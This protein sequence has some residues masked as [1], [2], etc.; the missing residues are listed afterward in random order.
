MAIHMDDSLAAALGDTRLDDRF[1]R[2]LW[3]YLNGRGAGFAPSEL[4]G[5][6]MRDRM[7]D[8]IEEHPWSKRQ[9][10]VEKT[11]L[12]LPDQCLTWISK[13]DDRQHQWLIPQIRNE[14]G[15]IYEP[16]PPRLL[17]RDLV[18]VMIDVWDTDASRKRA[19]LNNL[20][21]AW[22]EHKKQDHIFRWFRDTD[23]ARRCT[24]A[25]EWLCKHEPMLTQFSPA[26]ESYDELLKFF[27]RT[28]F[29]K[30]EKV[31]RIDAI[32]KRGSQQKYR[33]NL[34]GKKQYN[35]MLSDKTIRRL[36]ELAETYDLKRPQILE[37]LI[38]MEAESGIY[39]PE[40][41]KMIRNL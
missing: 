22:I 26:I 16:P 14:T 4:D 38:Q 20:E 3:F 12:L 8:F 25:W 39:I 11:R 5:A 9:I 36:D 32:K 34:T 37:I 6:I 19:V 15:F 21:Q 13:K 27:D 18:V 23:S 31:L 33:E 35:F 17:G 30:D 29:S 41:M 7:A 28:R 10:D 2:W 40:K 24:L 1:D